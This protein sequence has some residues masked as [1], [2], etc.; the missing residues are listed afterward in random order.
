MGSRAQNVI[1]QIETQCSKNFCDELFK[2]VGCLEDNATPKTQGDFIKALL[3]E[4][5]AIYGPETSENIM[6]P[7]GYNCISNATIAKAKKLFNEAA[8]VEEFLG[9]LN[10]NGFGAVIYILKVAM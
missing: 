4:I 7:C 2:K 3:N 5:N 8:N 10:Q 9:L 1:K 6:R